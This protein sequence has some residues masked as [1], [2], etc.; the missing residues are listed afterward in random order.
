MAMRFA[1]L[2]ADM[3]P[4]AVRRV[5]VPTAAGP[6]APV[7]LVRTADGEY[8]AIAD[9]CSHGAVSLSHG[10]LDGHLLECWGHGS[11]FDVRTGCPNQLPATVPVAVYPVLIDSGDVF[12]DVDNPHDPADL[13]HTHTPSSCGAK[14]AQNLPANPIE[15][16]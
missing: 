4:G 7:V 13:R 10:E 12:I 9:R 3:P 5:D 6:S 1:Y 11:Q 14:R 2:A 16:Q 15:E 8:H